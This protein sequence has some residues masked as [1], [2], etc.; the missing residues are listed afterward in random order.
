MA[1][2]IIRRRTAGRAPL[3][4]S[5]VRCDSFA[6]HRRPSWTSLAWATK[7]MKKNSPRSST[8]ALRVSISLVGML[9]LACGKN[10]RD[11]PAGSEESGA[12]GAPTAATSNHF[13]T[14]TG[15]TLGV[16]DSGAFATSVTAS[17]SNGELG[18]S[19]S[20][21]GC[22]ANG[23]TETTGPDDPFCDI[24]NQDC[25]RGHKCNP[26]SEGGVHDWNSDRCIPAPSRPKEIGEPC[27]FEMSKWDGIDD[28]SWGAFCWGGVCTPICVGSPENASCPAGLECAVTSHG[29]LAVC[30]PEC[31]PLGNCKNGSDLCVPDPDLPGFFHCVA[32]ETGERGQVFGPCQGDHDCDYGMMC[33]VNVAVECPPDQGCCTP[34]CDLSQPVCPGSGQ[35]CSPWNPN[36]PALPGLQDIGVCIL[37]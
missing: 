10:S 32:D 13:T 34:F 17:S 35:D 16:D 22:D 11:T 25:P 28:C 15:S 7:I 31:T 30:L 26:F 6:L 18:D 5:A 21:N 8:D 12:S 36:E 24:W 37:L 9:F 3:A 4:R 33:G 27:L 2:I 14:S 23:C 1:A 29:T 19:G 20:S